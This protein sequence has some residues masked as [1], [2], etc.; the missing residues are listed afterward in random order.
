MIGGI[1][2]LSNLRPV[3]IPEGKIIDYIDGKFRKDTPEEYVRQNIEKSLHLEYK[4]PK[5]EIAIGFAIKVGSKKKKVD[6]MIFKSDEAKKQENV[7]I[8]VETKAP[9]V[10]FVDKKEGVDQLKSYMA[11]CLNCEF[12]LWTN[13]KERVCLQRKIKKFEYEF[14][15]IGDIPG[16]GQTLKELEKIDRSSLKPATADNLLF[17]FNRCHDYIAGNQGLSKQQA[18]W[19]L[20]KIIFCKIDDERNERVEFYVGAQERSLMNGQLRVKERINK[21]FNKVTDF[22]GPIF[23]GHKEILLEP[24]VLAYIVSQLQGYDLLNSSVDV[25]G[26]AYEAIVGANLRGDRGEFFTPRNVCGMTVKMLDPQPNERVLDPAC[27]TGGF[28]IIALNHII[29]KIKE[30]EKKQWRLA[31][32]PTQYETQELYRKI[33]TYANN[34]VFGIDINPDLKNAT[35]MNM[36]MNND[37]SGGIF[38][39]NSLENPHKWPD[40]IKKKI[41][42]DSF[43]VLLTNPPFGTKIP[44]DDPSILDQYDLAHRW[45]KT[46][47]GRWIIK[48]ELQKSVPPE[49]LFIERCMQFLKLGTG[50]MAIVL[51]DGILGN[52]DLEYVRAWILRNAEILASIDLPVETFLPHTGT[53]TSMLFLRRKS[54]EEKTQ[55]ELS[56]KMEDYPVFMAIAERVGKDRRGNTIYKRDPEG[57]EIVDKEKRKIIETINGKKVVREVEQNVKIVDDDL[58]AIADAY[59]EFQKKIKKGIIYATHSD[60]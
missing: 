42:L 50:R 18:F 45:E 25:K 57:N 13:G 12:G 22:Y 27:G 37:G 60:K 58:P 7:Y 19:E 56:G 4:F 55:E 29:E 54:K 36:V 2:S 3:V 28:L 51:P 30:R 47:D 39:T 59:L 24:R 49:I 16:K 41:K 40:E 33:T 52:P 35:K 14:V 1:M 6:I 32:A 8:I 17:T 38:S 34:Y 23:H 48:E 20:V 15:E 46:K 11:A 9:K 44:I 43:D 53:Q 21:I 10:S 31:D 26:T 5:E